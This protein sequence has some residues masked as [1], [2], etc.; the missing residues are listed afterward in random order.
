MTGLEG[1]YSVRLRDNVMLIS[2]S[3]MKVHEFK[4]EDLVVC[5]FLG[6]IIEGER[7]PSTGFSMHRLI[8]ESRPEVNA[9]IHTH[10]IAATSFSIAN[11][12]I[13]NSLEVLKDFA[14]G[15]I[16]VTSEYAE[17][18]TEALAKNI[19]MAM[20]DSFAVLLRNH[21]VLSYG[22]DMK[23]AVYVSWAVEMAAKMVINA[24]I[25]GNITSID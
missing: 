13:P 5:S 7:K 21:G 23:H 18:G 9:V 20:N 12:P 2:P 6:E 15:K 24:S 3:G 10:S 17:L 8:Y 11:K 22:R 19:K 25:L 14:G 1:N 4:E 16:P